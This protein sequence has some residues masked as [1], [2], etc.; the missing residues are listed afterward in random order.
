MRQS[1]DMLIVYGSQTGTAQDLA[2]QLAKECK[3]RFGK[4]SLMIDPD[5]YDF[6]T[7]DQIPSDKLVVFMVGRISSETIS[8]HW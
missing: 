4:S 3:N 5:D 1:K 7:L 6:D 8:T 2:L